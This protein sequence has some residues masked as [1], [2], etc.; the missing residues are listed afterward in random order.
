MKLKT[1]AY[2]SLIAL[3]VSVASLAHAQIFHVLSTFRG[4]D[5]MHP[6]AGVTIRGGNSLWNNGFWR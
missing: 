3:V 2:L 5:G 1:I 4:S 6:Y